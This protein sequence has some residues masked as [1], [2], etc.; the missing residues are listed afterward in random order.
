MKFYA[1]FWFRIREVDNF[2]RAPQILHEMIN[3]LEDFPERVK[4]IVYPVIKRNS[5]CLYADNFLASLLYSGDRKHR[6]KAVEVILG[7]R[8]PTMVEDEKRHHTKFVKNIRVQTLPKINFDAQNWS[9]LIS[10]NDIDLFEPPC[11]KR[12]SITELLEMVENPRIPPNYP[13]HSQSVERAVALTTK[14]VKSAASLE[15]RNKL[16]QS[17]VQ[18]RQKR[19][20]F[21]NK[22]CYKFD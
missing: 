21:F 4:D 20:S 15:K 3:K 16:A 13:I 7:F 6:Q 12:L 17:I 14:V 9:E 1:Y 2:T 11:A 5:F 22:K 18:I 8:G 10:L 19:S